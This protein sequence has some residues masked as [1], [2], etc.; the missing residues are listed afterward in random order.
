MV[1]AA[2]TPCRR[3]GD[4]ERL[5][6]TAAWTL[7]WQEQGPGSRCLARASSD[8]HQ[9][10]GD[11]WR[12]FASALPSA[13]RV[14]DIG[15]GAGAVARSLG[16]A[17]HDLEVVGI[18][19]A[20]IPGCG[21]PGIEILS[22]TPMDEMPFADASFG[23]AV[24]QF[25]YEYGHTQQAASELARVLSAGAP[26][27]FLVHHPESPIM[28]D[29]RAQTGALGDLCGARLGAS[30]LS[31]DAAALDRVLSSLGHR[32]PGEAIINQAARGLRL[33]IGGNELHR[34][35]I[36]RAVTESLAPDRVLQDALEK[37]C[38]AADQFDRWL[39]PLRALFELR[40]PSVVR[41]S[42]GEPIARTIEGTRNGET[43]R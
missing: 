4:K 29:S 38:V 31:G 40:P 14:L 5:T 21:D 39:A 1:F 15:C 34:A 25:G 24:S 11:H 42:S 10:L 27:S 30:F 19:S 6:G 17:R 23:A 22:S 7:F 33:H 20:E 13:V 3:V 36:W 28:A 16:V 41:L 35:R 2:A 18:D 32:Y 26:I 9:A 12:S 37:S 8:W 43:A